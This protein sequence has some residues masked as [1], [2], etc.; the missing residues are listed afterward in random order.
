MAIRKMLKPVEAQWARVGGKVKDAF[1]D[2]TNLGIAKNTVNGLFDSSVKM[3]KPIVPKAVKTY[4]KESGKYNDMA[5]EEM[6]KRYPAGWSQN[7]T[8][9]QELMKIR[10]KLKNK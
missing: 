5:V 4:L 9:M 10:K 6:N 2:Q 3:V 7:Y 8:H 1:A